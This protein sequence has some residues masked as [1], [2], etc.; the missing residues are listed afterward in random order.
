MS[1]RYYSV[2]NGSVGGGVGVGVYV[3]LGVK[4]EENELTD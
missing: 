4:G 3:G 1:C 2:L